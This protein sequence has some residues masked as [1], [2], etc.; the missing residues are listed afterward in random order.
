MSQVEVRP[1]KSRAGD[2][3]LAGS[4]ESP[5][6]VVIIVVATRDDPNYPLE[7]LLE[8]LNRGATGYV[9]NAVTNYEAVTAVQRVLS[10]WSPLEPPLPA[11]AL[12]QLSAQPLATTQ[13]QAASEVELTARERDV[14]RLLAAGKT[15]PQIAGELMLSVSTIKGHV[16]HVFAKLGVSDRT[17]AAVRGLGLGLLSPA[18]ASPL[19]P[20]PAWPVGS[21]SYLPVTKSPAGPAR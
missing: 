7:V 8:P 1:A 3:A 14:L 15:N 21:A 4:R 13:R 9:F 16:Q 2:D 6:G 10:A 20:L 18:P 17:E 19:C 12:R 5:P 11:D